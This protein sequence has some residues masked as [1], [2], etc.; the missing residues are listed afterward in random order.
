VDYLAASGLNSFSRVII[1]TTHTAMSGGVFFSLAFAQIE[2]T[3]VNLCGTVAPVCADR[4]ACG[5]HGWE[6]ECKMMLL[7][8][9]W[10]LAIA[11]DAQGALTVSTALR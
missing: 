2:R 11:A 5:G 9:E 8:L 10:L 6:R 1:A 4:D 3:F 7:K